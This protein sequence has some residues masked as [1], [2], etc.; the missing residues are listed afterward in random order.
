M[1]AEIA[2][3]RVEYEAEADE[4]EQ[5]IHQEQAEQATSVQERA[6]M[7]RN[8]KADRPSGS[9]CIAAKVGGTPRSHP[10]GHAG[11]R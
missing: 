1:E 7:A 4:I 8:R 9:E 3:L 5:L 11:D 10:K 6:E 2:A